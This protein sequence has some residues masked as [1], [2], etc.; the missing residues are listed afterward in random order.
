MSSPKFEIS[1]MFPNFLILSCSA[2]CDATNVPSFY[3]VNQVSFYLWRLASVLK[4]CEFPKYYDQDCRGERDYCHVRV[5]VFFEANVSRILY[6]TLWYYLTT[7]YM[8]FLK[9][10]QKTLTVKKLQY[11]RVSSGT[12]QTIS[13]I[14][15]EVISL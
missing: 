5:D 10:Y 2:T 12:S 4:Q 8:I 15:L 11:L 13:R 14:T 9:I 7:F 1:L 6:V 3:I